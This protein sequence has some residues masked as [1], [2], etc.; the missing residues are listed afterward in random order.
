M[1]DVKISQLTEE[2][3]PTD[4]AE[5]EI[6]Q[7]GQSFKVT[8]QNLLAAVRNTTQTVKVS[9]S[10]AQLKALNTSPI[11]IIV[12]PGAN[13]I[14]DIIDAWFY[15]RYGT[16]DF[17]YSDADFKFNYVG[18]TN[19]FTLNGSAHLGGSSSV[20]R[21]LTGGQNLAPN[22]SASVLF[23]DG[24]INTAVEVTTDSD[25]TTGDG[26]VVLNVLY[27]ITDVSV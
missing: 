18:G 26:T 25:A 19:I 27:R 22:G 11:E 16:E 20:F 2:I 23:A 1:A 8:K 9:L 12:A 7:G 24:D 10:S 3:N 4:A 6:A 17:N 14:V 21:K 5:F 13:N 15:Y